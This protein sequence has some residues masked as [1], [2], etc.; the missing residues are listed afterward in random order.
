VRYEVDYRARLWFGDLV[1]IEVAVAEVGRTSVRYAF[2]VR[3]GVDVAATGALVAVH[4]DPAADG[5]QPWPSEARTALT[6]AG[7]QPVET[8]ERATGSG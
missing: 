3:R 5:V 2:E 6:T 8:L 7:P 4:S 1:D